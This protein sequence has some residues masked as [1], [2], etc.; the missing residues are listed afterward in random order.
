MVV[1]RAEGAPWGRSNKRCHRLGPRAGASAALPAALGPVAPDIEDIHG[2]GVQ[3]RVA[4]L[5]WPTSKAR[6][7]ALDHY[8]RARDATKL[9]EAIEAKLGEQRR[10]VLWCRIHRMNSFRFTPIPKKFGFSL[11]IL[12]PSFFQSLWSS[13]RCRNSGSRFSANRESARKKDSRSPTHKFEAISALMRA[14]RRRGSCRRV[15]RIGLRQ[16]GSV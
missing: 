13:N 9:Y 12:F 10:F 15:C 7:G 8:A 11:I 2:L 5:S 6:P 3:G 14:G 16:R 4:H 1:S